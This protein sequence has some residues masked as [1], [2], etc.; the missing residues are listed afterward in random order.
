MKH[1]SYKVQVDRTSLSACHVLWYL[2]LC[3]VNQVA[4]LDF[5]TQHLE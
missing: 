4:V 5:G 3:S 1:H 2:N